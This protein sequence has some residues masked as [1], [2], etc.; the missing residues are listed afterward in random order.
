VGGPHKTRSL[1]NAISDASISGDGCSQEFE[2]L[3]DLLRAGPAALPCPASAGDVK[4]RFR[5]NSTIATS[6]GD[7]VVSA[8][9]R[10]GL[11]VLLAAVMPTR[12]RVAAHDRSPPPFDRFA[13]SGDSLS[14]PG[15]TF[16]AT[17]VF[18][19]RPF[20]QIAAAAHPAS[21][22]TTLSGWPGRARQADSTWVGRSSCS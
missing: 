5:S 6:E 4:L 21:T 3:P 16:V 18:V 13:I 12:A 11:V 17:G 15:I 9:S 20:A 19:V 14:D 22:P 2:R 10:T 7:A 1:L 8:M